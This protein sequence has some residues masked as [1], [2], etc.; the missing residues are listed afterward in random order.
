MTRELL[1]RLHDPA[2]TSDTTDLPKPITNLR[3]TL[4]TLVR[5]FADSYRST[6]GFQASFVK[7]KDP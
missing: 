1:A 3:Y 7:I 2:A 4:S 5:F 6:F